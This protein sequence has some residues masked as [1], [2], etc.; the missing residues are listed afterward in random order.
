MATAPA[1]HGVMDAV[2]AVDMGSMLGR[3]APG[4]VSLRRYRRGWLRPDVLAGI[5]VAAYLVPQVM[6]Y[7]EVA[8][9]LWSMPNTRHS[10]SRC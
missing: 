9:V 10:G 4:L 2:A 6:A 5:T 1:G 7:A 3:V 8:I